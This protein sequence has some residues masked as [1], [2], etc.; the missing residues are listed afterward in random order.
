MITESGV[1]SKYVDD[2]ITGM[3]RERMT[4]GNATMQEASAEFTGEKYGTA[5]ITQSGTSGYESVSGI[6]TPEEFTEYNK[7]DTRRI[8]YIFEKSGL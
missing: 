6:M 7:L 8:N 5:K 2:T 3:Q 4:G 1:K